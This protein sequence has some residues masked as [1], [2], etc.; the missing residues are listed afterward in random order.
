MR[1][2]CCSW[3]RKMMKGLPNSSK[4]MLPGNETMIFDK[5]SHQFHTDDIR[6]KFDRYWS[7]RV[8]STTNASEVERFQ[9]LAQLSNGLSHVSR[10]SNR[11]AVEYAAKV[12]RWAKQ[13]IQTRNYCMRCRMCRIVMWFIL[14]WSFCDFTAFLRDSKAKNDYLQLLS[15]NVNYLLSDDGQF[16]WY[17]QKL[18]SLCLDF[19]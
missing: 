19:E 5:N 11:R 12:F 10:T 3:S 14:L 8:V 6:L 18:R 9:P 7:S 13:W 4:A 1:R 16:D 15:W 17:F 2:F